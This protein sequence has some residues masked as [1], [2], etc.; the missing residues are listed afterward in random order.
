[1]LPHVCDALQV[2]V[3]LAVGEGHPYV[4]RLWFSFAEP[5]LTHLSLEALTG[6]D[7]ANLPLLRRHLRHAVL[8]S[9]MPVTEPRC[10]RTA[11]WTTSL[12]GSESRNVMI[13]VQ[14]SPRPVSQVL[15]RE[16]MGE[17]SLSPL[18]S[19]QSS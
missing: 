19:E 17:S 3:A 18:V 13:S 15:G 5:P 9:L 1:M 12:R 8:R 10:V 2:I 6:M 7:L 4:K 16:F 11:G 14:L